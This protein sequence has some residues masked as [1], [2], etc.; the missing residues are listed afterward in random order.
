MAILSRVSVLPA[1]LPLLLAGLLCCS[2]LHIGAALSDDTLRL[3]ADSAALKATSAGMIRGASA[4]SAAS[5]VADPQPPFDYFIF[6]RQ[7]AGSFCSEHSCPK[8]HIHGYKFTIHGLWPEYKSGRWPQEC[9]SNYPFDENKITDLL[10]ELKEVWPT[11]FEDNERFWEHEWT[12]HGTCSLDVLPD[13]HAY[14][15]A[16]LDLHAEYDLAAAFKAKGIVPSATKT[17]HRSELVDAVEDMFGVSARVHCDREG[18]LSEVWI[19][20]GKDLEVTECANADRR[21]CDSMIIPP[22]PTSAILGEQ[23]AGSATP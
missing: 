7:W 12:K 20:V 16:V 11:V 5:T 14:F 4:A 17:Y 21:Q 15:K 19:C 1:P 3:K 22:M 2:L 10:P 23:D 6:V 9:D 18:H 8:V 13:E